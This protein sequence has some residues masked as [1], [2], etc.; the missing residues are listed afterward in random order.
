MDAATDALSV[1]WVNCPQAD[2]LLSQAKMPAASAMG[3]KAEA[4]PRTSYNH[5][6]LEWGF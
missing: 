5:N 1:L 3:H 2:D 6:S 4:R